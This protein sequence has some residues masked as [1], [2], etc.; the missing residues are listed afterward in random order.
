M[1]VKRAAVMGRCM[2]VKRAVDMALAAAAKEGAEGVFTLGPL[3]HNP[4]AV[5]ELEAAG[6]RAL[7]EAELDGRDS[8]GAAL[9][10]GK[11][12]VIR[13]HGVPPALRGRLSEL[14]ARVI[15]ATCPRVLASQRKA[16]AYA[17]RGWKVV[18]AGDEGHGE[19]VGIAGQAPGAV[20]V[21]GPEEAR[22]FEAKGEDGEEVPVVLIAQTT[23]KK[24]EYEAIRN[25]LAERF[26]L[27]EVVDSI[28]PCTEDR[29]RALA[30][31][32]AEV[33]AIVIVG[34]R[35]SANTA[36]LLATARELA[37]PAWLVET[38]AELPDAVFGFT[39]VGLSAGASTP[40][41][42]IAE[43]EARLLRAK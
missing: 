3:I 9:V 37:K 26:P 30:E 17:A 8:G 36:R 11:T 25:V 32:A 42:L 39:K 40:E 12:V 41:R 16:A 1:I 24:E 2:G 38:A 5:A 27:L 34:G 31:L 20:V 33:E 23:I 19:V 13:A 18:I 35:N 4:Q 15:D 22:A 21:G 29:L 7:S 6:V 43:V 10:A 14:G 28:C